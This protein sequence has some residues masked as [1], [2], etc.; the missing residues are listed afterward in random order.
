M[1]SNKR[2]KLKVLFRELISNNTI[3]NMT[4]EYYWALCT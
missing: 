3:E 4:Y 2:N 1:D